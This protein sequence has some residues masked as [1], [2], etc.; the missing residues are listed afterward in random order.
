MAKRRSK[1]ISKTILKLPDLEHFKSA[2]L[3]SLASLSSRRSY[4]PGFHR[5]VLLRAA[6]SLQQNGRKV[7]MA[8]V[9][10]LPKIK[11]SVCDLLLMVCGVVMRD[12]FL[13]RQ[14]CRLCQ[15]NSPW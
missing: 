6:S 13:R 15:L 7:L 14:L 10:S 12:T 4:D 2:V 5:L 8:E 3:N 1:R 11:A 9:I